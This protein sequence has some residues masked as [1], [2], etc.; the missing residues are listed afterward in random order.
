VGARAAVK[1]LLGLPISGGAAPPSRSPPTGLRRRP[2]VAQLP[3]IATFSYAGEPE[4]GALPV[5]CRE[6]AV[7]GGRYYG[8][9]DCS[10]SYPELARSSRRSRDTA[11]QRRLWTVSEE[12][13]GVTFPV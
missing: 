13:T 8:P 3:A 1:L 6:P 11:I 4:R 5:R 10:V 2:A 9:R 12:L 7:V